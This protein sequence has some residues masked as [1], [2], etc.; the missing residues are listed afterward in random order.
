MYE[1]NIAE[2]N[3]WFKHPYRSF[4]TGFM[5]DEYTVDQTDVD[6]FCDYLRENEPDLIGIKCIVGTGGISFKRED[7]DKA[8]YY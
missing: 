4:E 1:E 3:E 2:L 5:D 8:R 6:D 7:L